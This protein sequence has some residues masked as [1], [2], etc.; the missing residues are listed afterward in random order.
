MFNLSALFNSIP[1]LA[2][3]AAAAAGV[4]P[5][6]PTGALRLARSAGGGETGWGVAAAARGGL[7]G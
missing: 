4:S 1:N 3:Y 5:G 2:G 6:V 7:A